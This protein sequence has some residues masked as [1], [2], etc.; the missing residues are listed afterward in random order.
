MKVN[1]YK[2][3]EIRIK[4]TECI[5]DKWHVCVDVFADKLNAYGDLNIV[6]QIMKTFETKQQALEYAKGINYQ[7]LIVAEGGTPFYLEEHKWQF[8]ND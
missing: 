3:N 6:K 5:G 7:H 8:A 2:P 1:Q 4:I